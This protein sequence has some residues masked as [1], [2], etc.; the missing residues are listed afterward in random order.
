MEAIFKLIIIL[1]PESKEAE[2]KELRKFLEDMGI[3]YSETDLS[4]LPVIYVIENQHLLDSR[5]IEDF[6]AVSRAVR[7]SSPSPLA[8]KD[9]LRHK[10]KT[11]AVNGHVIG[12]SALTVIA[13]PCSIESY[14]Q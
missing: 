3:S 13:G 7:L 5:I 9:K 2:R 10:K 12:G 14:E 8:V 1:K 4:G 11:I 6:F